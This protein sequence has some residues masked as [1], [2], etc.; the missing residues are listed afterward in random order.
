MEIVILGIRNVFIIF[1]ILFVLAIVAD[2]NNKNKN[3]LEEIKKVKTKQE[4][5]LQTKIPAYNKSLKNLIDKYGYPIIGQS[6]KINIHDFDKTGYPIHYNELNKYDL[7]KEIISFRKTKRIWICGNDFPMKDIL[8]STCI[9]NKEII[10]GGITLTTKTNKGNMAK[11]AIVGGVLLGGVGS[12][13]GGATASKKTVVN[14][15]SDITNHHYTVIINTNSSSQPI[16]QINLGNDAFTAKQIGWIMN[17]ASKIPKLSD[18][19]NNMFYESDIKRYLS[20][21]SDKIK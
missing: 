7:N 13:I 17:M 11:R 8:S 21:K 3:R 18:S 6:I 2:S 5:E 12:I 15:E 19:A 10:K 14:Q 16:I 1:I 20:E 9:D 4:I